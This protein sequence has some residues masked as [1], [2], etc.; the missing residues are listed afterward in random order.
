MSDPWRNICGRKILDE[1]ARTAIL[2]EFGDR[3][4]KALDAIDKRRVKRYLDFFIVEG[5]TARYIVDDDFCTCSDFLYRGR[6]CWHRIAMRIAR[7]TE[8]FEPVKEWY[9]ETLGR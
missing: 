4:A 7:E 6:I 3:G 9:Q 5:K 1:P 2:E 8:T